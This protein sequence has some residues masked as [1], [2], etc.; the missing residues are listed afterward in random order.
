MSRIIPLFSSP[1]YMN[2]FA[3]DEQELKSIEQEECLVNVHSQSPNNGLMSVDMF[4]L[5]RYPKLKDVCINHTESFIFDELKYKRDINYRIS[6]SWLNIHPPNH[7]SHKHCHSNSKF[8][9]V[10]YLNFP[11]DSGDIM[12]EI[13][14]AYR[15]IEP[16]VSEWNIYNSTSWKIQ[17]H[18]GLCILFPSHLEHYTG[19]NTTEQNRYSLAF[20]VVV[21]I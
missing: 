17:P 10:L 21:S 11:K 6:L 14:S 9:G 3:L 15:T 7:S 4:I 19:V 8:S 1:I 13:P 20:D 2:Q 12:F 16:E 5:N 18:K